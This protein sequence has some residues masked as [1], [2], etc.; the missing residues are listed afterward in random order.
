LIFIKA[1]GCIWH[2]IRNAD[3]KTFS[4]P[5]FERL[6]LKINFYKKIILLKLAEQIVKVLEE[7]E[8]ICLL[9]GTNI[10]QPEPVGRCMGTLFLFK[11]AKDWLINTRTIP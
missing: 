5:C 2:Q 7:G 3:F 8:Q 10:I 11:E 1:K 4:D 9:D 6:V